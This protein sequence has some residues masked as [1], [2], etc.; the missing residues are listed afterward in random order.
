MLLGEDYN[1]V[2]QIAN[3]FKC[4]NDTTNAATPTSGWGG[5]KRAPAWKADAFLTPPTSWPHFLSY[6]LL[7]NNPQSMYSY[8]VFVDSSWR[9]DDI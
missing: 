1:I 6:N 5:N 2:A 9:E 7:Y 4:R 3:V 8:S